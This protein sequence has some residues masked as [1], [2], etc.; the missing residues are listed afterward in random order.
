MINYREIVN[1]L[2]QLGLNRDIPLLVHIST[3]LLPQVKGGAPTVLGA[4]LTAVD[5]AML[6]SFTFRT[7]VIPESGPSENGIQYG[8]G[9]ESN[10]NAE[11]FT[12]KLL[13]DE[14]YRDMAESMRNYPQSHH[15][16]HPILSFTGLGLDSALDSQTIELPYQPI[17]VLCDLGGWVVFMDTDQTS[18]F[19]IHLAEY[20]AGRKQFTRWALTS[21]GVVECIHFPGCSDGFNKLTYHIQEEQRLTIVQGHS[22]QAYPLIELVHTATDLLQKDPFSLLCNR[23][24][25]ERCNLVR[26]AVKKQTT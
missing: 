17:Q 2:R 6:P 19:S 21:E 4:I 24:D 14:T 23:L 3:D 25:C 12:S 1:G 8:S 22:W 10:L 13:A 9:R 7:Q 16:N 26:Q 20:L 11:I 18:N 5:N 15:S